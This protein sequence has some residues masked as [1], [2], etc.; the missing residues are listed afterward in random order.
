MLRSDFEATKCLQLAK[1]SR[2]RLI[3]GVH[4]YRGINDRFGC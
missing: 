3:Q 4:G 1:T 2:N